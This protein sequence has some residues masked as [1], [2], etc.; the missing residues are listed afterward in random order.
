MNTEA[1][2]IIKNLEEL[3]AFANEFEKLI[4]EGDI[5]TLIGNLGTGKTT[6]TQLIC[7]N[8]N[9]EGVDSPSFA[10]VNEYYGDRVVY[11]FDF[12]RI[13]REEELYDIGLH[14]YLNDENAIKFI[15]WADMFPAVLPGRRI[16]V[17]IELTEN[18]ERKISYK[19]YE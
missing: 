13:E 17:K 16:E 8:W 10:L 3:K 4:N 14:E 15:E 2:V 9:I 11:H 7:S 12:Y 19:K 5:V 6:L 18:E 1:T